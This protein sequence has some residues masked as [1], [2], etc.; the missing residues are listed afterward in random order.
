MTAVPNQNPQSL[1]AADLRRARP[2]S[3]P[4]LLLNTFFFSCLGLAKSAYY[5]KDD[6]GGR[7]REAIHSWRMNVLDHKGSTQFSRMMGLRDKDDGLCE[8]HGY[9]ATSGA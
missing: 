5:I 9:S 1:G 2:L 8:E 7:Y 6:Q 4:D 3:D